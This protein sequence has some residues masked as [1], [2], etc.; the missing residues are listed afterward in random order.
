MK[1]SIEWLKEYVR[2]AESPE[3]LKEDL[4]MI[5]LLVEAVR[6]GCRHRR[7][8]DRSDLK[9][10]GLSEPY[11]NCEGSCALSIGRP[12]KFPAGKGKR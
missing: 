11:W 2:Y 9:P 8:R 7:S 6:R 1:I 10:A 4:S 12:L 3:K 5:G